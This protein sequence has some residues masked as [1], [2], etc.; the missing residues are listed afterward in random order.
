VF[1]VLKECEKKYIDVYERT[2]RIAQ[3]VYTG[4]VEADWG[5]SEVAGAFRR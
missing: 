2:S 5:A 1:K 3:D 4:E